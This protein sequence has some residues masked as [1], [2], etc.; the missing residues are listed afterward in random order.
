MSVEHVGPGSNPYRGIDRYPER[1]RER[2]LSEEE[3]ARL[4]VVLDEEEPHDPFAVPAIRLLLLTG[5]RRDEILTLRW[6][7]VNFERSALRLPDSKTG[8]KLIPLGPAALELLGSP[9]RLEGNP[10]VIPGRRTGGR[11]VGVQRPWARIR[12]KAGLGASRTT[13]GSSPSNS[14]RPS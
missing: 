4:G 9:P 3:L 2:F 13:E 7:Q 1:Q 10:Y 8:A 11:L 14:V 12:A 6:S 5:A